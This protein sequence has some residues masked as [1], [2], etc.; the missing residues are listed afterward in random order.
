[1]KQ[2]K[3]VY[4]KEENLREKNEKDKANV[5]YNYQDFINL[6][7]NLTEKCIYLVEKLSTGTEECIIC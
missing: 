7:G 1:M 4:Y 5:K 3:V 6:F 2:E